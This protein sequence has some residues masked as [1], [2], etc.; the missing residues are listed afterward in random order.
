LKKYICLCLLLYFA[1]TSCRKINKDVKENSSNLK[2]HKSNTIVGIAFGSVSFV[3][4]IPNFKDTI[5]N[6]F[7]ENQ[8]KSEVIVDVIGTNG[9]ICK[10]TA[11]YDK[12]TLLGY[13]LTY[14]KG[15]KYKKGKSSEP[16]FAIYPSLKLRSDIRYPKIVKPSM[17]EIGLPQKTISWVND[18][19]EKSPGLKDGFGI[20]LYADHTENGKVDIVK[21]G[22]LCKETDDY[23]CSRILVLRSGEWIQIAWITPA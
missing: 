2:T 20:L 16:V 18:S 11:K 10:A 1:L 14:L 23:T 4:G 3:N 7:D 15:T 13:N 8:I 9:F 21:V 17:K 19:I 22:G 12:S 5:F 6:G